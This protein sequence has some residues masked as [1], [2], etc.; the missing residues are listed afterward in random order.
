[1]I[2]GKGRLKGLDALRGLAALSVCLFHYTWSFSAAPEG[3][4]ISGSP[5][6]MG[7]TAWTCSS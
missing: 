3:R 2:A 6:P 1:M 7:I 5:G 4:S